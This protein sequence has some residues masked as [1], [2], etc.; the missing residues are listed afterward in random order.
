VARRKR[1]GGDEPDD[2]VAKFLELY[3][4]HCEG[5]GCWKPGDPEPPD[6]AP[7][8]SNTFDQAR[9]SIL[10]SEVIRAVQYRRLKR[11]ASCGKNQALAFAL[12]L[13]VGATWSPFKGKR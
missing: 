5:A 11:K 13:Y 10:V 1:I 3:P 12:A 9:E 2:V 6:P 4:S 8:G 7:S